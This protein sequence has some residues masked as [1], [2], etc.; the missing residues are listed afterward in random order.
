MSGWLAPVRRAGG[1]A[2]PEETVFDVLRNR[3]RRYALHHLKQREGCVSVSDLA[4]QV[5]AWETETPLHE[6][7]PED[8]RRVY[9]SLIQ[10]HL[11]T[12]ENARMVRFDEDATEVRL[13]EAAGD[14]DVYIER[15]PE[16]DIRWSEYYLGLAAFGGC[17]LIAA[18][19]EVFPLTELPDVAWLG[20]VTALFTLSA[21]LHFLYQ[22]Q[23]RLGT[24]GAPPE[25]STDAA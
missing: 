8:R 22:R 12:M 13:T 11:P 24:E 4:E 14:V 1:G 16:R 19:L 5:A 21:A 15:V 20:F 7:T 25:V 9:I 17:F 2:L 6:V 18:H 23:N 3:R 10:T